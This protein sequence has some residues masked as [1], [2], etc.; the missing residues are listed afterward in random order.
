[1]TT[2]K[3]KQYTDAN[4]NTCVDII[5][6]H[7]LRQQDRITQT[8]RIEKILKKAV[9]AQLDADSEE[10]VDT[11]EELDAVNNKN[12]IWR[13]FGESDDF[14]CIYEIYHATKKDALGEARSVCV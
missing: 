13:L 4:G 6:V 7:G 8:V 5:L 14:D 2:Q 3:T 11:Q 12:Y 1:M 9:L 10:Y